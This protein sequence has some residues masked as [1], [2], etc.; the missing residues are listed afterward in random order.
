MTGGKLLSGQQL[1]PEQTLVSVGG[2]ARLHYQGDG[3]LV[4]YLDGVPVWASHTDGYGACSLKMR[5][6]GNL[7]VSD[8]CAS[9]IASTQTPGHPGAM[10]QLQDDGNFVIYE[11]PNGPLAGTPIWASASGAF[12]HGHVEPEPGPTPGPTPTSLT[13]EANKRWFA[14]AAGRFDYRELSLF[15]LLSLWIT[16]K[17]DEAIRV[18]DQ[19]LVE[20]FNVARIIITLDGGYWTETAKQLTGRS[21]RCAPDMPDYEEGLVDIVRYLAGRGMYARIVMIGAVEPFGG[22]W[23][24]DRRDVWV[25]TSVQTKGEAFQRRVCM[26]LKDEPNVLLEQSN[27]PLQIGLRH[28]A[29]VQ[30][31]MALDLKRIA[32]NRLLNG[33]AVDGNSD[34][35]TD[36][37]VRPYDFVDAHI[38]RLMGVGGMEWVKRSGE[39]AL[40]DQQDVEKEMP[41][42]SGETVNFGDW[43]LDGNNADVERSPSVAFAYAACSRARKYNACFHHDRGLWGLPMEQASLDCARAFHAALD[44]FPMLDDNKWRGGWAP[45]QGNYWKRDIWPATDDT[46]VV[47]QHVT[48]GKGPW[49]AF[50]CGAYSMTIA[51]PQDWDWQ[52]NVTSEG[53]ERLALCGDGV[54]GS[55]VY[56][57]R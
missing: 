41:F 28:S 55:A 35:E 18:V 29:S 4:V 2:H 51:E 24:P 42:V 3:N 5:A 36:Y 37:C 52:A 27:E 30:T 57:R 45:D 20:R 56:V 43:R 39:Y 23:Y 50:G 10:V 25:G 8:D 16:D 21:L 38:N 9:G 32:P 53:V 49:R 34:Q 14:N 7:V 1:Q 44:A 40:I 31:R 6:D 17:K 54:Y 48:L 26:L 47:D 22:I 19:A 46:D 11:D 15:A 13:V 33:G 12:V